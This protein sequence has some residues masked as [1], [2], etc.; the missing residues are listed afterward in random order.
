MPIRPGAYGDIRR[1]REE[2]EPARGPFGGPG[3][4]ALRGRPPSEERTDARIQYYFRLALEDEPNLDWRGVDFTVENGRV[5]LTGTVAHERDKRHIE[6]L[7]WL[8][9]GVTAVDNRIAV[10][11]LPQGVPWGR[12]RD[13]GKR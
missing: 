9:I 11:R 3:E 4:A 10:T 8:M 2:V 5:T 13:F 12:R 6:E 1:R 7:A